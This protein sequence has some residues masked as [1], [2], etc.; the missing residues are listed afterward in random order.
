MDRFNRNPFQ[1]HA[2]GA[3]NQNLNPPAPFAKTGQQNNYN[4]SATSAIPK[5]AFDVMVQQQL[6]MLSNQS[7]R[8]FPFANES[9]KSNFKNDNKNI[10]D[11]S[12]N[13]G[14]VANKYDPFVED[15]LEDMDISDDE[16]P[17]QSKKETSNTGKNESGHK[18]PKP[19][20]KLKGSK[21]LKSGAAFYN[22]LILYIPPFQQLKHSYRGAPAVKML[23]ASF[24]FSFK[25][26]VKIDS[27][28]MANIPNM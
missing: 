6:Q 2:W 1:N 28:P 16:K 20:S 26:P 14:S 11:V 13:S 4:P 22:G 25:Q 21:G 5:P 8:A 23:Y 27:K 7:S 3:Q 19:P 9:A 10:K 17:T 12:Q 18:C 24:E 15:N